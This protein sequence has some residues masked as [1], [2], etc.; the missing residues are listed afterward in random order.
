VLQVTGFYWSFGR[1][2]TILDVET[3]EAHG[4]AV[5]TTSRRMRQETPRT[6]RSG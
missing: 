1:V 3:E 6:G 4:T 2:R 5:V